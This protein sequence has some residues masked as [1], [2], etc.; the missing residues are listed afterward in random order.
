MKIGTIST[1][2]S[3]GQIVAS[4]SITGASF[5]STGTIAG[6]IL[7]AS[8]YLK[9]GSGATTPST[10][11][12]LASGK[13]TGANVVSNGYVKTSTLVPTSTTIS[14]SGAL[15]A[16]SVGSFYTVS[17]WCNDDCTLVD[18]SYQLTASC[19]TGD[20]IVSCQGNPLYSGY[21]QTLAVGN[22]CIGYASENYVYN[23]AICFSPNGGSPTGTI[24]GGDAVTT[25]NVGIV[26]SNSL[27]KSE[28]LLHQNIDNYFAMD[29]GFDPTV[30]WAQVQEAETMMNEMED[31]VGGLADGDGQLDILG[32]LENEIGSSVATESWVSGQSYATQS[33]VSGNYT[34]KTEM[35]TMLRP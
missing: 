4:G 20:Q 19:A 13:I 5:S 34:N 29:L 14:V 17:G 10:G 26:F 25:A 31:F 28:E 15:T 23:Q 7:T 18:G 11:E 8:S 21:G 27:T 24:T 9:V 16:T 12:I 3:S 32:A 6:S 30:L 1:T 2:P 22:A 35:A 33:W